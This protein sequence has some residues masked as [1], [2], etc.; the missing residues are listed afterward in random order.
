MRGTQDEVIPL[1]VPF[2]VVLRGFN[3]QQVLDHI[4]SL[5]GHMAMLVADRDAALGQVADLGKV[6]E[7]LRREAEDAHARVERLQRSSL[8]GAGVRIQRMLQVAEDEITELQ[9]STA[10]ETTA[11]RERTRAEADRLLR[12]TTQRC[13]RQ[14]AESERRRAAA[15]LES[16]AKC[17]QA[18][19]ASEARR[20]AAEQQVERDITRREAEA[21]ARIRDQQARSLA[22]LH[23]LLSVAGQQL[24]NRVTEVERK[25]T[26]CT[27]LQAEVTA[28]LSAAHSLLTEVVGHSRQP[29]AVEQADVPD[30][31]PDSRPA[32]AA[33][34]GDDSAA[35]AAPAPEGPLRASEWPA[36]GGFG[37]SETIPM[38][39]L[40]AQL[41][42]P[43]TRH[44]T[45]AACI[46]EPPSAG[47]AP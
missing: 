17:R 35:V 11:L 37:T 43:G 45:A 21:D 29:A 38:R 27:E 13:E 15:E 22:A 44:L 36:R 24:G 34:S 40:G 41:S 7:H 18:E 28:R 32:P 46:V 14:E 20:Q 25:V 8:G 4:E 30:D 47:G 26:R 33:D 5:E 10:Q 19:Q 23:L 9:V 39:V 31:G 3:R 2:D 42:G 1:H 6:L 12:E 16:A